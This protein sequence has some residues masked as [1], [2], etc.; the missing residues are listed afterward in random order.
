MNGNLIFLS[1]L[2]LFVSSVV[3][4]IPY[5]LILL[6]GIDSG[7][8]LSV[9]LNYLLL[10]AIGVSMIGLP[11]GVVAAFL[12]RKYDRLTFNNLMKVALACAV[13]ISGTLILGSGTFS[14]IFAPGILIAAITMALWCSKI[15]LPNVKTKNGDKTLV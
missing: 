15:L 8:I 2:G 3:A 10:S 6:P 4:T 12:L 13:V 9:G 7:L 5:W 1:I 14:V 11:L